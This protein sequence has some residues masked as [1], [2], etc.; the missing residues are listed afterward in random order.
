VF[1]IQGMV[2]T[3]GSRFRVEGLDLG[4]RFQGLPTTQARGLG[5]RVY[6]HPE[7]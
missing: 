5:C 4:F 7:I 2:E 6:L 1:G 3:W